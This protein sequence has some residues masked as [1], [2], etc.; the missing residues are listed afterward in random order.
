M[1]KPRTDHS[2]CRGHLTGSRRR[3]RRQAVKVYTGNVKLQMRQWP[4]DEQQSCHRAWH[5]AWKAAWWR[6]RQGGWLSGPFWT[7]NWACLRVLLF[8]LCCLGVQ[9]ASRRVR[10]LY[11]W[12][13]RSLPCRACCKIQLVAVQP[14]LA[15]PRLASTAC[16]GRL[17]C[18]VSRLGRPTRDFMHFLMM[19]QC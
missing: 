19:V 8:S 14:P 15:L 5:A 12:R 4:A 18:L 2:A 16:W 13:A 17:P 9:V 1:A 3:A 10:A 7:P 6:E 11:A